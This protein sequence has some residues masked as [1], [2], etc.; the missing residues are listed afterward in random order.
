MGQSD[1]V[2]VTVVDERTRSPPTEAA[3]DDM[4]GHRAS[5]QYARAPTSAFSHHGLHSNL[6]SGGLHR[7]TVIRALRRPHTLRAA[8]PIEEQMEASGRTVW[9]RQAELWSTA[10]RRISESIALA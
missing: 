9:R 7:Y 10:Q 3:Y 2:T 4:I 8:V 6:R 5:G 1:R